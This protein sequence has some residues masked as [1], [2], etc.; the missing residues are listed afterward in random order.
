MDILQ[1][2][3]E[4]ID[5]N[6]EHIETRLESIDENLR[7]HMRRTDALE[8]LHRDNELRIQNLEKPITWLSITWKVVLGVLGAIALYAKAKGAF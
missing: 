5:K 2:I 1:L 7:E 6:Q 4:K 3:N 8:Q